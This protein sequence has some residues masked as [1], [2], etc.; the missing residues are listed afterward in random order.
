[1]DRG[2]SVDIPQRNWSQEWPG[3]KQGY[4]GQENQYR[5]FANKE[6]LLKGATN[7]ALS[8]ISDVKGL[9]DPLRALLSNIGGADFTS[10]LQNVY[11]TQIEPVLQRGGALTPEQQREAEQASL[12]LSAGARMANSNAGI[13]NALLNRDQFRRQRFG[14]ALGEAGSILSDRGQDIA[15]RLGLTSGIQGVT[16]SA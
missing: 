12:G 4:K 11:K 16:S 14:E 9:S 10:S 7:L 13:A 3:I 5:Q 6:P 8:G 1:M 2:G 15:Q